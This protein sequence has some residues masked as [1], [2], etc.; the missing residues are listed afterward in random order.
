[1]TPALDQ[2]PPAAPEDSFYGDVKR[3][4][5]DTPSADWSGLIVLVLVVALSSSGM[6]GAISLLVAL[7]LRDLARFAVMKVVGASDG[8]LLV[9][10]L[11][12]GELPIGTPAGKEATLILAGPAFLV[13]ASLVSFIVSRFTGP[14]LV[15]ELS[16]TS[17]GLVH[18]AA[19]QAV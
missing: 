16:R 8:R 13:L 12:R 9:L 3:H 15:L 11:V 18:P 5:S 19:L 10:P 7:L 17:V 4:L 1:M 2:P 6:L 14:G